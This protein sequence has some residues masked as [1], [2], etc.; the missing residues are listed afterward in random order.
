MGPGLGEVSVKKNMAQILGLGFIRLMILFEEGRRRMRNTST[1]SD[2][3]PPEAGS[4]SDEFHNLVAFWKRCNVVSSSE[5][6]K[7][8][9]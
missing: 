8:M 7:A 6:Q 5:A 3:L 4:S 2:I 9:S 1:V